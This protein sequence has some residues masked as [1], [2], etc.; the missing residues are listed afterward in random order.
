MNI[1][2]K[3]V[4]EFENKRRL[5]MELEKCDFGVYM[6][7]KFGNNRFDIVLYNKLTNEI[8]AILECKNRRGR[9]DIDIEKTEQITLYKRLL[10]GI[11]FI[12]VVFNDDFNDYEALVLDVLAQK[13]RQNNLSC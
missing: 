4:S 8:Q 10:G 2:L 13:M 9:K 6:E 3:N 11:P 5:C 12:V 7:Y 1:D